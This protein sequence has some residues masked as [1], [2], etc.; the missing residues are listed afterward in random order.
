MLKSH[1][2]IAAEINSN[3]DQSCPG[4]SKTAGAAV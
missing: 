1:A 4:P 2:K 3:N